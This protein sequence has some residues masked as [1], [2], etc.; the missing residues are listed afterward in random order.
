MLRQLQLHFPI[1]PALYIEED[2]KS[3]L[4]LKAC[5]QLGT[6]DNCNALWGFLRQL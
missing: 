2:G 5:K 4:Y 3:K 6:A 1:I